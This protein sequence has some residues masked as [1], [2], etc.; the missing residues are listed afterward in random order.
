MND[1]DEAELI[2]TLAGAAEA[3]P[4]PPGDLIGTVHR[5]R[6]QRTRRRVQSALAVAGVSAM[7][8]G[9]TAV[10]KGAFSNRG[11][12]GQVVSKATSSTEGSPLP[13]PSPSGSP[14]MAVRPAAEVWP[15]AV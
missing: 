11:G 9:G 2:R 5:R 3:A 8:G 7:I 15:S 13:T 14:R 4:E 12:E 10:A 6:G 1:R